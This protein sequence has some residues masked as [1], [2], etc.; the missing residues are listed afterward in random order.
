MSAIDAIV[1]IIGL[2][3][4]HLASRPAVFFVALFPVFVPGFINSLW[5]IFAVFWEW[6]AV[7]LCLMPLLF[8][9]HI[10]SADMEL[11]Q[12]CLHSGKKD[13]LHWY[14][15][16]L[17]SLRHVYCDVLKCLCMCEVNAEVLIFML[18][19]CVWISAQALSWAHSIFSLPLQGTFLVLGLV[20]VVVILGV[21]V[22]VCQC[23]SVFVSVC[24]CL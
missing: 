14:V 16:T 20:R 11:H 18:Y 12:E 22:S 4:Y 6:Y 17:Q 9:L 21:F 2:D 15:M 19:M 7:P 10:L 23:L 13:S 1:K 24:Q 3:D 8:M 5:I